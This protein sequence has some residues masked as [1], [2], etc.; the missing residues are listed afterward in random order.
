MKIFNI[1][2]AAFLFGS[3]AFASCPES[4]VSILES[5]EEVSAYCYDA[6]KTFIWTHVT[7]V[8]LTQESD[9]IVY[10]TIAGNQRFAAICNGTSEIRY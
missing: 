10:E 9:T 4:T 6:G 5:A 8:C 2:S 7:S 1:V 3:T